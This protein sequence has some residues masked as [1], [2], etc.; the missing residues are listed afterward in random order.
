MVCLVNR[1]IMRLPD[2]ITFS[3]EIIELKARKAP[4][5]DKIYR[6]VLESNSPEVLKLERYI[7]TEPV[8]IEVKEVK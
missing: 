2:T 7:A 3:A 6:L 8:E 1:G 5:L 4:S